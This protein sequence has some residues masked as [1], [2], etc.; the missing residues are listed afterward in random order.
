MICFGVF[1]ASF[2]FYPP[3]MDTSEVMDTTDQPEVPEE[4]LF[5]VTRQNP[6]TQEDGEIQPETSE[7]K[8]DNKDDLNADR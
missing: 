3:V 8:E 2:A 6:E 5:P 1:G 7:T 4:E